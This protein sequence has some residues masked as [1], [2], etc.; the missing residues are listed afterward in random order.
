MNKFFGK[1]FSMY[2]IARDYILHF[3]DYSSCRFTEK[4]IFRFKTTEVNK[5]AKISLQI[6]LL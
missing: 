4:G 3:D 1:R 5:E 6:V 2:C